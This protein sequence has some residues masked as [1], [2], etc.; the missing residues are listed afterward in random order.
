MGIQPELRDE[1]TRAKLHPEA[2][3]GLRETVD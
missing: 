2:R 1:L 3:Q